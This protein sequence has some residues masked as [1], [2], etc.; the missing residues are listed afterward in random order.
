MTT[1]RLLLLLGTKHGIRD[2]TNRPPRREIGTINRKEKNIGTNIRPKTDRLHSPPS[3]EQLGTGA[4]NARYNR[5][6]AT[7]PTRLADDGT[8]LLGPRT[9]LA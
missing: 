2:D 6:A 8:V 7:L 9:P 4:P 3:I 5:S 1:P